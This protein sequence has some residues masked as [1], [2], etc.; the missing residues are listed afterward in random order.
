MSKQNTSAWLQSRRGVYRDSTEEIQYWDICVT[1]ILIFQGVC[2]LCR[3]LRLIIIFLGNYFLCVG[4]FLK[5]YMLLD[6]RF[7]AFFFESLHVIW[8]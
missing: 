1:Y 5:T 8:F 3:V 7:Y 4:F 2:A 6:F